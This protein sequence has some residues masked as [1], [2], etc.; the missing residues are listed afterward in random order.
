MDT[1][2]FPTT[3]MYLKLSLAIHL[4]Q[5]EY[6]TNVCSVQVIPFTVSVIF[7]DT[8]PPIPFWALQLYVWEWSVET[9]VK[10]SSILFAPNISIKINTK[11]NFHLDYWFI[12]STL[13]MCFNKQTNSGLVDRMLN[14]FHFKSITPYFTDAEAIKISG[15][16]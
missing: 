10:W 7:L 13:K 6:N 3:Y 14:V 5:Y 11:S 4:R 2:Y 8:I 12:L 16:T 15:S 1:F 9:F